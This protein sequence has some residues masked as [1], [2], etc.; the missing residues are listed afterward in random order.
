MI[1]EVADSAKYK[2]EPDDDGAK[3]GVDYW[4]AIDIKG[5]AID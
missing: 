1:Q 3:S 2:F 5:R 4:T